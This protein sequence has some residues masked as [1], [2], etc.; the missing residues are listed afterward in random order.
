MSAVKKAVPARGR[1]GGSA[2]KLT[3]DKSKGWNKNP[4]TAQSNNPVVIEGTGASAAEYSAFLCFPGP[5]DIAYFT[6]YS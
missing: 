3:P 6:L 5:N 4:I 1:G 2:K